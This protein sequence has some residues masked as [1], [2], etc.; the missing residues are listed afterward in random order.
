MGRCFAVVLLAFAA[1][2]GASA[3]FGTHLSLSADR[4]RAQEAVRVLVRTD[5]SPGSDCRMQ[6]L[7]VAPGVGKFRALD[8]F[9][10]GGYSINGPQGFSFHP[11]RP[12]PR[13]GFVRTLARERPKAWRGTIRFPSKGRWRLIVPNW[14]SPGYTY[15]LPVDRIV[16]VR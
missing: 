2:P 13:M 11:I 15:P 14:C 10:A 5:E 6:L 4:P 16:T 7:A 9:I 1:A 12:T 8:A 3:K